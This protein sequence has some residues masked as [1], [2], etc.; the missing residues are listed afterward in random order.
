MG[1]AEETLRLLTARGIHFVLISRR[2]NPENAV[3]LLTRRGL[4]GTYFTVKNAFFVK[5]PDEKNIVAVREGVTHFFDDE[6]KVLRVMPDVRNRFL[7]D[8]SRQ[9]E[10]EKDLERIFDW[11]MIR[12]VLLA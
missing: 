12:R 9:F 6:R 11:E 8:S 3:T 7:F 2:K 1:G 5:S 4:W 10:D